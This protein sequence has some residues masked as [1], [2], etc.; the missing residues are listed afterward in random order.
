MN[1]ET[2]QRFWLSPWSSWCQVT[3]LEVAPEIMGAE[4]SDAA[5]LI[6]EVFREDAGLYLPFTFRQLGDVCGSCVCKV[7]S[8][9]SQA[10]KS[11]TYD[12][13]G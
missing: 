1:K 13:V 11:T 3:V 7:Y 9:M 10:L 12:H 8:R 5:A 6:R 2:R 4:D